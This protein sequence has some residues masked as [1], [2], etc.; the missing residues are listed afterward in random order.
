MPKPNCTVEFE[1]EPIEFG[2]LGRRVVEGCLD[3]GSMTSDGGVMLLGEVDRK[4]GLLDA[5]ARCVADPRSPLLIKHGVRDMLRQ[6][7]YGLALGWEDLND[8][9][10]L[11]QDVAMQTAVG[12]DREVASA[13]TLCR[14][15]NWADRPSAWRLHEVLV[16]QFIA[17][18]KSAPEE[19]VL[20]FDATDNPLTPPRFSSCWSRGCAKF[21]PRCASSFAATQGFAASAS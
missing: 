1:S 11:R 2:R 21:G 20:D 18:F 8:H 3:G 13:P 17:S 5:A 12:V 4:I 10:A 15:E 16:D 14:L 9:A 7:V 19:L 6:R